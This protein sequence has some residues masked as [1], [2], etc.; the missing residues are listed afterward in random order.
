MREKPLVIFN[1]THT[2]KVCQYH[3]C[4]SAMCSD[5]NSASRFVYIPPPPPPPPLEQSSITNVQHL[6][7][8]SEAI[9]LQTFQKWPLQF[10]DKNHLAAAGF[11]FT[12]S[13]DVVCSAFCGVQVGEW[14][15][16]VYPFK[17]HQLWSP[18]SGFIIGF[19]VRNIPISSTDQQPTRSRDVC[20]SWRC[21]YYCLY[22]FFC[23]VCVLYNSSPIVSGLFRVTEPRVFKQ[24]IRQSPLHPHFETNN[25][26]MQSF[27]TWPQSAKRLSDADF[28]RTGKNF[29]HK[30][31][32]LQE[33]TILLK[34]R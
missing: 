26:R 27:N 2:D 1:A 10:I 21:K 34:T 12:Y 19:I 8:K 31:T 28:F 4:P 32:L 3:S 16:G 11:Y 6:D 9:R 23:Y 30:V 18:S 20:G 25:A 17:K 13:K 29:Q 15:A 14:E 5:I 7:T 24:K 22:L 33:T